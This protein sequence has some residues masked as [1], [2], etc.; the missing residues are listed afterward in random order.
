MFYSTVVFAP[1][2]AILAFVLAAPAGVLIGN[3]TSRIRKRNAGA[4]L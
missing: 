2:I 1:L 4:N 3:L